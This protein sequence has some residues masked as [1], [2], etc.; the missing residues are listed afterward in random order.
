M[1]PGFEAAG[2]P[3]ASRMPGDARDDDARDETGDKERPIWV[4]ENCW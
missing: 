4:E 3:R 2:D 1:E